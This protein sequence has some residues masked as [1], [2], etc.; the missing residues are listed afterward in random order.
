MGTPSEKIA[1][2]RS[3][4][5]LI[6]MKISII[7]FVYIAS[8]VYSRLASKRYFLSLEILSLSFDILDELPVL[9]VR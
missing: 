3:K 2:D 1:V 8:I 4:D 7:V 5:D 6:Q 9:W